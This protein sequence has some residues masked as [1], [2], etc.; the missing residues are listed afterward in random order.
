MQTHMEVGKASGDP[1][2]L[3]R[4]HIQGH[5]QALQKKRQ[6][7]APPL[8]GMPGIPGGAGPGVAGTPRMGAQPQ[9]PRPSPQPPGGI[10]PDSMPGGQPRG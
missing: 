4:T 5:M 1:A 3:I 6:M 10:N 8:Q 2:G 7:A 9:M